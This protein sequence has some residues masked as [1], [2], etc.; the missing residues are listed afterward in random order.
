MRLNGQ[1]GDLRTYMR[2]E[3]VLFLKVLA[4]RLVEQA[5]EA[6]AQCEAGAQM[7]ENDGRKPKPW[8]GES[9]PNFGQCN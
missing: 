1:A 2:A 4:Q 7:L 5:P 8:L 6:A 3:L 9:D